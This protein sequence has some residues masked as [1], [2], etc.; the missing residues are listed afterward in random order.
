MRFFLTAFILVCLAP[1]L[2][3]QQRQAQMPGTVSG[4]V[5]DSA[6]DF[7]LQSVTITAYKKSDSTLLAYQLTNTQGEFSFENIPLNTPVIFNFS[8]AGYKPFSKNILLDSLQRGYDFRSVLLARSYGDLDEVVV[9][10]VLPVKMNGDT[11]E[12]NP[13]AFKLDSN[14]V[15]EDMLRKVP[16]VTMWG[17]GSITVNGKPVTKVYVDGKPFFGGDPAI[18]TQNL[19]KTAIE[20][21]QVYQ[22]IDYTK[23]NVDEDPNDSL[24]TMNIKLKE[25]RKIGFFGKA[26]AGIG[27]DRRYEADVTAQGYNKKTRLGLMFVTNNINKSADMQ[28]I[29]QQSTY[30][31]FNPTNRYVANFGGSGINKIISGGLSF[32]HNFAEQTNNRLSNQLSATYNI[33]NNVNNVQS[34]TSTQETGNSVVFLS[35]TN[36]VSQ[37]E[38]LNH[39]LN[40]GYNKRDRNS[41]FSVNANLNAGTTSA[42]SSSSSEKTNAASGLVS[43]NNQHSTSESSNQNLS[44]SAGYRKNDDDE[45]N[46]KSFNINYALNY[47]GSSSLR[48]TEANFEDFVN[49]EKS[50][51]KKIIADNSSSNF[52]NNLGF[53]YNALKRLLFGNHNFWDINIGFNNDLI[54]SKSSHNYNTDK[55][56]TLTSSY[57][58]DDYLTY[59]NDVTRIDERPSLRFSKNFRKN[60]SDR[61]FRY[62][63]ISANIAGQFLSEQNRSDIAVRNLDRDYTF[64][65][66]GFNVNYSFYRFRKYNFSANL[67]QNNSAG[68]PSIEQLFPI[69]DTVTNPYL[70]N[71]GN[72]DLKPYYNN[73]AGFNFNYEKQSNKDKSE[74]SF[75]LSFNAGRIRNGI[76]DSIVYNNNGTRYIYLLNMPT[77][78]RHINAGANV[79]TSFKLKK[80]MLQFNYSGNYSQNTSPNYIDAIYSVARNNNVSHN[81]RVF[82]SLGDVLTF[83]VA[84]GLNLTSNKQTGKNLASFKNTVY[85]TDAGL[86]I[87]YPKNITISNTLSYITNERVKQSATLWNAFLV[88]RFLKNK[89]AEVKFSAMDILRQ[90]KNITVT[91]NGTNSLS[92]T[93]TNGLRQFYMVTFAYYPRRFGSSEKRSRERDRQTAEPGETRRNFEQRNGNERGGMRGGKRPGQR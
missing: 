77:G 19:P 44:V 79:S 8:F 92:T 74:L 78:R 60:L 53:G 6:N 69:N 75:R 39:S 33:R 67:Y 20:K 85:N 23:D 4:I 22:E 71:Y 42:I 57:I 18:A 84:Q 36:R 12:I 76:S 17:D 73:S 27:T 16:G 14:A 37:T 32:Q 47:S 31:N 51:V 50:Y 35:E 49:S 62:L 65:L 28:S 24:L 55:Y 30:R 56:D 41:D 43:T 40:T 88:Y 83:Q 15:V 13:A 54:I 89:S 46:L 87:K 81:L 52:S 7:G 63:N 3:A 91:G 48:N 59:N 10:A 9:Q 29:I 34:Q 80:D 2:F 70:R 66:P 38:N 72:P 1:V 68:L 11:L 90:N 64:F 61:F 93:V 58:A 86:N 82:Y 21:I 5:K 26:G 45:R 25:E